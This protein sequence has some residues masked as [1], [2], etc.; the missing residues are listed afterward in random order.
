MQICVAMVNGP[1]IAL[2]KLLRTKIMKQILMQLHFLRIEYNQQKKGGKYKKQISY[3]TKFG[4]PGQNTPFLFQLF[5]ANFFM[6]LLALP[7]RKL[8]VE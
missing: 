3:I 7:S 4:P 8:A 1:Q 6:V 5:P 2:E